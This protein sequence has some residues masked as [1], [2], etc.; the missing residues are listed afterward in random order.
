MNNQRKKSYTEAFCATLAAGPVGMFY[1][2]VAAGLGWTLGTA[3]WV[4]PIAYIGLFFGGL[5]LAVVTT[6]TFLLVI[7]LFCIIAAIHYTYL[8]NLTIDPN[9]GK[10]RPMW[11]YEEIRG[12][13]KP[14]KSRVYPQMNL[15]GIMPR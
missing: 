7:W 3:L 9:E 13:E 5:F 12:D 15:P 10:D 11:S 8:H 6:L 2:S 14:T 4:I 1:V